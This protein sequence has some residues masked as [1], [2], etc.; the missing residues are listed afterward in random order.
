MSG[1]EEKEGEPE[2]E[3]RQ[4]APEILLQPPLAAS[5]E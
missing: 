1:E 5:S 4:S 2:G 3:L